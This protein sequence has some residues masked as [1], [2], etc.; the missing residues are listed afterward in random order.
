MV[1][2]L[3]TSVSESLFGV[4]RQYLGVGLFLIASITD[5]LDGYLARARGEITTLGTLLDPIADKLLISAAL[6]ALVENKIAP[7]WAVVIII[8]REFAVSGLRSIAS[9]QGVVIP[10]SKMGKFKML[11]EVIAIVLLMLGSNRGGPPL[12]VGTTSVFAVEQAFTKIFA[13]QGFTIPDLQIISYGLGR[14]LMWWVVISAL[15][16]MTNYFKDFYAG[17]RDRIQ[18]PER[19]PLRELLHLRPRQARKVRRPLFRMIS[20]N[21]KTPAPGNSP[22]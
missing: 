18:T 10:A 11:S 21:R 3:M 13:G 9:Q 2:V 17:I 4:P 22:Q 14:F 8:G 6:I 5:L 12:P 1:V 15:W 19:R 20:R 7:G 16:S